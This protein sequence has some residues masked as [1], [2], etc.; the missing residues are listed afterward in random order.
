MACIV[1]K[2][3]LFLLFVVVARRPEAV[4]DVRSYG[5]KGDG[6]TDNDNAFIKAWKDACAQRGRSSVYI[7]RGT[8]YMS[9]VTFKGPCKGKIV[10]FNSGT[11]LAPTDAKQI[12]QDNMG[13]NFVRH[14]RIRRLKSLNSKAE[15]LNIFSVDDFNITHVNITAP[16]NSPNTDG[17]KIGLSSNVKISTVTS[18]PETTALQYSPETLASISITSLVVQDMGHGFH[19]DRGRYKVQDMGIFGYRDHGFEILVREY[20]DG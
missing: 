1:F 17:I 19:R 20:Q 18:A 11:L 7:P 9:D 5:A 3:C 13:L 6:K 8:F 14:S 12:K 4:F 16:E 15:H 2:I 10:F